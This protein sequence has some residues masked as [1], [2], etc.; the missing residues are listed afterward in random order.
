MS[1]GVGGQEQ[2]VLHV[3]GSGPSTVKHVCFTQHSSESAVHWNQ[4]N[5]KTTECTGHRRKHD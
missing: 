2:S 3:L 4:F 5:N 1:G